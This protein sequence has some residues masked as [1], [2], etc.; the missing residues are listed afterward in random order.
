ME[1]IPRIKAVAVKGTTQI[2]IHFDNGEKRVYDC[3]PLLCHPQFHFLKT[4]AFFR[5]AQVDS[6][7]YGVSWNDDIDLS[8]YEL[9]THGNQLLTTHSSRPHKRHQ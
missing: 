5:A 1:G 4:P 7:G 6:G 9:R 2:L 8:E 3:R